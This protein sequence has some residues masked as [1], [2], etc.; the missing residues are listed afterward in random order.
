MSVVTC[1]TEGCGNSGEPIELELTWRD[2]DGVIHQTVR[3][4]CGVCGKPIT[5]IQR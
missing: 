2:E 5:D 4:I 1:H 3:V